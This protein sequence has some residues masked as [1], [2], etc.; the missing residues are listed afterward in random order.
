[1][2]GREGGP[3]L[4]IARAILAYIVAVDIHFLRIVDA[5]GRIR[6]VISLTS[7]FVSDAELAGVHSCLRD[8]RD[9][10]ALEVS[11]RTG[12]RIGDVLAMRP[13]DLPKK[14]G[15]CS[16]IEQKTGKRRRVYIGAKLLADL[17]D[18]CGKYWVFPGSEPCRHRSYDAL[19]KDVRAAAAAYTG[20]RSG[21]HISPH[22]WRKAYAVQLYH[23]YKDLERVRAI[24]GHDDALCTA[25]YA[26]ADK[27]SLASISK[28]KKGAAH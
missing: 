12:L 2:G 21:A 9:M 25:L 13:S 20:E 6:G 4:W 18:C 22:S 8:W 17:R 23:K 10:L 16:V 15:K 1:M 7:E 26:F 5:P 19:Y 3:I 24:M 11:R 14:A 27:L 28:R